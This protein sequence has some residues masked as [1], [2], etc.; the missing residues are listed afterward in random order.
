MAT[1]RVNEYPKKPLN[2]QFYEKY[3][4]VNVAVLCVYASVTMTVI[5]F[6]SCDAVT[7]SLMQWK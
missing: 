5:A 3:N 4:V 2:F 1:M 6:K 7:S